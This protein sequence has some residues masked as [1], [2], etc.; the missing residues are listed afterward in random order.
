MKPTPVSV[1]IPCYNQGVFLDAA[2][3]SV[4]RQTHSAVECIVVDDG[5]TEPATLRTLSRLEASGIRILRQPNGGLSNARNAGVLATDTPF[6]V[7]LD[8][9]DVLEPAFVERLLPP[10]LADPTLGYT[11]C[12]VRTFGASGHVW[13]CRPYDPRRLLF[14]NLSAATAVVRREAFDRAGGYRSDMVHG[15]EDWDFWIALLSAGYRGTCV[16]EPWFLYRKHARGTSMLDKT[17]A[18]RDEMIRRIIAHHR[19]L[20][21][22][23]LGLSGPDDE[24]AIYQTLR[25]LAR[26]DYLENAGS[27]RGLQQMR[28]GRRFRVLRR[29]IGGRQ[30]D[31]DTVLTDPRERL[32]AIERSKVYRILR[33][34]KRS[35]VYNRYARLRYGPDFVNP[36]LD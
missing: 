2:V 22:S 1:V 11:Y 9:D 3:A 26:L 31:A 14:E 17:R 18:H 19:D 29:M 32:A 34:L 25:A 23:M 28:L 20:M 21:A 15:F 13:A 12:H 30:A 8:A 4:A 16:A 33:V 5:S 35:A 6:F 10:L 7:P 24:E 27:W 36:F